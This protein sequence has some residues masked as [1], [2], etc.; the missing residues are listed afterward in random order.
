MPAL[1]T[2]LTNT[3][4]NWLEPPNHDGITSTII[5]GG[6]ADAGDE[7]YGLR[8]TCP[9]LDRAA[10]SLEIADAGR[11]PSRDRGSS[12]GDWFGDE[13]SDFRARGSVRNS[14]VRRPALT[15]RNR[16]RV[17]EVLEHF[18]TLRRAKSVNFSPILEPSKA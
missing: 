16:D 12:A 17:T 18:S 2:D 7:F 14:G 13:R 1:G 3:I 4:F 9:N 15:W 8:T 5:N 11:A 10:P 6:F